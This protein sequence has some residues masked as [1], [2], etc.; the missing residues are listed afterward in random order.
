VSNIRKRLAAEYS[1]ARDE[2]PDADADSI[3]V[4]ITSRLGR[5]GRT[6]LVA[7]ELLLNPE[8]ADR[9]NAALEAVRLFVLAVE[10]EEPHDNDPR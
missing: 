9:P 4:L 5:H 3:A 6:D 1:L 10:D 7:S 2:R 8:T